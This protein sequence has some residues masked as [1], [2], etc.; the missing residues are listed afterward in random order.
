MSAHRAGNEHRRDPEV[1]AAPGS[2]P[3]TPNALPPTTIRSPRSIGHQATTASPDFTPTVLADRR[4]PNPPTCRRGWRPSGWNPPSCSAPPRPPLLA[5][6]NGVPVAAPSIVVNGPVRPRP[7]PSDRR[8]TGDDRRGSHST[9]RRIPSVA[10]AEHQ[11]RPDRKARDP[12]RATPPRAPDSLARRRYPHSSACT[13]K[14]SVSHS[15]GSRTVSH[16]QPR[17]TQAM[18]VD[19]S[20]VTQSATRAGEHTSTSS[21][22]RGVVAHRNVTAPVA[23]II[24]TDRRDRPTRPRPRSKRLVQHRHADDGR[25]DRLDDSERGHRP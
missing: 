9:E 17:A 10:R 23:T 16:H 8:R 22:R 1:V 7:P 24:A 13:T 20:Q 18:L 14:A 4:A 25:D 6:P 12:N 15:Q 2:L 21:C 5:L 3:S 11:R 19:S